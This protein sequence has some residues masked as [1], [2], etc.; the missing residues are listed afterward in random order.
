[1]Y[2]QRIVKTPNTDKTENTAS[3]HNVMNRENSTIGAIPISTFHFPISKFHFLSNFQIP[4]QYLISK[5]IGSASLI[6]WRRSLASR[7]S[8]GPGYAPP[9]RIR[10]CACAY[11]RLYSAISSAWRVAARTRRRLLVQASAL[12][13]QKTRTG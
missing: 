5:Y 10:A 1:M 8:G 7:S 3:T 11:V 12:L 9:C 4:F 6:D 13:D 2:W